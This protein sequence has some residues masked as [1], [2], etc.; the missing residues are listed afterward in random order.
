MYPVSS[1]FLDALRGSHVVQVRVRAYDG[2]SVT[3]KTGGEDLRVDG[4]SVNLSTS[5]QVRRSLDIRI[6]SPDGLSGTARDLV[7]A[8]GT[9]LFVE[10][11]VAYPGAGTEFVPVGRYIVTNVRDDLAVP[12]AINVTAADLFFAL[13][14]DPFDTAREAPATDTVGT[15]I[16][17]LILESRPTASVIGWDESF[18]S[19]LVGAGKYFEGSRAQTVTDLA[20]SVGAVVYADAEGIFRLEKV[21]TL[22]DPPVWSIDSGARG[23][24]LGGTRET[25]REDVFTRV[26]VSSS[27]TDGSFPVYATAINAALET[28]LGFS[29]TKTVTLSGWASQAQVQAVADAEASKLAGGRASYSLES[30]SN[31]A[32]EG[33]DRV[34]VYAPDGDSASLLIDGYTLPLGPESAMSLT[35]RTA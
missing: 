1:Y 26:L 12:G 16:R 30:L 20:A 19:P 7:T 25:A 35:T 28:S 3:P 6:L 34:D 32:L 4:G 5:S 31:P 29:R 17:D 18:A 14:D 13:V 27:P 10:R 24:M 2:A 8:Y 23:V 21:K 15:A 33:F 22:A 9:E 11:G